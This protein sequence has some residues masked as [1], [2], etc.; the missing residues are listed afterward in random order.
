MLAGKENSEGVD[1]IMFSY[2]AILVDF[3][4]KFPV[5]TQQSDRYRYPWSQICFSVSKS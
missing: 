4:K 2:T 1:W 3:V 5:S